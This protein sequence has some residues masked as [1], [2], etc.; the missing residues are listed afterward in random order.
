MIKCEIKDDMF[1]ADFDGEQDQVYKELIV[2]M[3]KFAKHY[4]H[5]SLENFI[6]AL[7][8]ISRQ[9]IMEQQSEAQNETYLC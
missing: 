5:T 6:D 7:H 8:L 1:I 3:D 2:L 9:I 4:M